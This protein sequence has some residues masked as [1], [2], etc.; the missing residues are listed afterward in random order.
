MSQITAPVINTVYRLIWPIVIKQP[1]I[2]TP[3]HELVHYLNLT[4]AEDSRNSNFVR[5][6]LIQQTQC[7]ASDV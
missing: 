3:D 2:G 6:S 1:S 5:R 7:L 4:A